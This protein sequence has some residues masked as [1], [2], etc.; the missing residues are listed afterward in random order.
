MQ[1][2]SEPEDKSQFL[3]TGAQN[4]V[5]QFDLISQKEH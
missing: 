1:Y 5:T 3:S 4:W 2:V